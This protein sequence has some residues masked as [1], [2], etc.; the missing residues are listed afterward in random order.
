M[1]NLAI[2]VIRPFFGEYLIFDN[3]IPCLKADEISFWRALQMPFYKSLITLYARPHF[4][5]ACHDVLNYPSDISAFCFKI[6]KRYRII[7]GFSGSP[8]IEFRLHVFYRTPPCET[9]KILP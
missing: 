5:G 8:K 2:K 3:P 6:E 7:L 9:G 4:H 1:A